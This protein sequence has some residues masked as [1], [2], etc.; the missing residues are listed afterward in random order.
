MRKSLTV[1]V[2]IVSVILSACKKEPDEVITLPLNI[3]N[4]SF[5][6][7][8]NLGLTSDIKLSKIDGK[9]EGGIP[10][11]ADITNLVASFEFVG[12]E[13]KIGDKVQ[14]S[15]ITKN[16]FSKSVTYTV[17][18][19]DGT[20][21]D[22]DVVINWFT[23]LP[24]IKITTENGIEITSKD[25][26]VSGMATIYGGES[27]DNITGDMKIRGR[28]HSTWG[29]HPKKPF[30]MRFDEKTEVLGMPK[31][32]KWILLAEH[33]D[34][35]LLRNTLAFEMGKLS[36]LDWTPNTVFA[37]VFIND[38]YNGTYNISEKVEKSSNRVQL[39]DNG[40]LLEIDTP[41]HLD[42]D[43][44]F[45]NSTR[46]TIQVKEPE[47]TSGGEDYNFIRDYIIEFENVLYSSLF[48]DPVVGYRK[49]ID[50]NSFIDWY[51]IN[52]IA[53]NVDSKDYSSMYFTYIPGEKIKMGPLWDF[54]LGFGNVDY[55][56]SQYP[57]GFWVKDHAWFNRLMKDPY[58]ANK[59]KERYTY[60][61]GLESY[62]LQFIDEKADYLHWSVIENDKKW[63]LFGN[64]VWPIP[65]INSTYQEDI[66]YLKDWLVKRL[67]WLDEAYDDL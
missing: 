31:E 55:A 1:L 58:F 20:T 29:I 43:D 7:G 35:T 19:E 37:E 14:Q 41:D 24:I 59:V 5:K 16:D 51:L 25:E 8:Y 27:Y 47:I 15:G 32:K 67:R 28:G 49:Y 33:S 11:E 64:Y 40:Y 30:Q 22:Y 62:F 66:Y 6:A 38:E 13:V 2:L 42:P 23:G 9:L 34:K 50:V 17:Y 45:F 21:K 12:T 54:D 26:Y 46:F 61:Y 53:K 39:G 57:E 48:K 18:G 65:V 10:I 44:V 4:F 60:F 52:E 36:D 63:E 3:Y 56:D